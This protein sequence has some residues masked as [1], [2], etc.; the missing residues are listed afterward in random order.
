VW[1]FSVG[2]MEGADKDREEAA[3]EKQVRAVLPELRCHKQ[4]RGRF[5]DTDLNWI[6]RMLLLCVSDDKSGRGDKRDWGEIE[7]WAD[8]VAKEIKDLAIS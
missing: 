3:V 7:G 8:D 5:L 1:A 6:M 2:M 4:F